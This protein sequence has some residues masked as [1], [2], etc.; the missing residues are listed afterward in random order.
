MGHPGDT[1][2]MPVDTTWGILH[3]S[4]MH[5]SQCVNFSDRS[6]EFNFLI[7]FDRPSL[8]SDG[9]HKLTLKSLVF[10]RRFSQRP[11]LKKGLGQNWSILRPYT[12]TVT[13]QSQHLQPLNTKQKFANV[14]SSSL[15]YLKGHNLSEQLILSVH[16]FRNGRRQE[17][18]IDQVAG[19]QKE[20][21]RR[22]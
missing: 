6:I 12:G 15:L 2:H 22:R 11:S 10:L 18:S 5:P 17:E 13:D 21:V 4:R 14:S 9:T 1:D 7:N 8:Q 3:L 16:F 19:C 20:R